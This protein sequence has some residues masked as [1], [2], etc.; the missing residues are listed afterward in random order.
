MFYIMLFGAIWG[1]VRLYKKVKIIKSKLTTALLTTLYQLPVVFWLYLGICIYRT[2]GVNLSE[3]NNLIIGL[4]MVT[5]L[6]LVAYTTK[7]INK[8]SAVIYWLVPLSI[9]VMMVFEKSWIAQIVLFLSYIIFMIYPFKSKEIKFEVW[10]DDSEDFYGNNRYT[11]SDDDLEY[12]VDDFDSNYEAIDCIEK[13]IDIVMR[14]MSIEAASI[15]DLQ[16]MDI[17]ENVSYFIKVNDNEKIHFKTWEYI[18]NNA[19]RIFDDKK[20]I[21]NINDFSDLLKRGNLSDDDRVVPNWMKIKNR[22]FDD[23]D[24]SNNSVDEIIKLTSDEFNEFVTSTDSGLLFTYLS[25]LSDKQM[26][27]FY[28]YSD[29]IVKLS[30][31]MEN[32]GQSAKKQIQ[33]A[34]SRIQIDEITDEQRARATLEI[35]L[36]I[37]YAKFLYHKL[38]DWIEFSEKDYFNYQHDDYRKYEGHLVKIIWDRMDNIPDHFEQVLDH[39]KDF[40]DSS[41][42]EHKQFAQHLAKRFGHLI[43]TLNLLVQMTQNRKDTS[44]NWFM[45]NFMLDEKRLDGFELYK[46]D[47]LVFNLMNTYMG[48]CEKSDDSYLASL[49]S[50]VE[51]LFEYYPVNREA[52]EYAMVEMMKSV[53]MKKVNV[54]NTN[55]FIAFFEELPRFYEVLSYDKIYELK[56]LIS[57]TLSNHKP[58]DNEIFDN[59]EVKNKMILLNYLIDME[60]LYYESG[61]DKDR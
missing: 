41:N 31:E 12:L 5:I 21:H 36:M 28:K 54:K 37:N 56:E 16:S 48:I 44:L 50:T 17:P 32:D 4:S 46:N 1:M 57:H 2:D 22:Q 49:I 53:A 7:R 38:M 39:F 24:F 45:D 60:D 20:N 35:P 61:K 33:N 15:Q 11:N 43:T 23:V 9:G 52:C 59:D 8:Y 3:P 13:R 47:R 42:D 26:Q 51:T 14:K 18:Q 29:D 6:F 58:Q 27:I 55:R 40:Y 19:K 34:M 25:T 10:L 30:P